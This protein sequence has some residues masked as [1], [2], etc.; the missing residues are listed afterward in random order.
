MK[1]SEKRE[2]PHRS[3]A[4]LPREGPEWGSQPPA[5]PLGPHLRPLACSGPLGPYRQIRVQI[6]PHW[7]TAE[8]QQDGLDKGPFSGLAHSG[9]PGSATCLLMGGIFAGRACWN[10]NPGSL[11]KANFAGLPLL[12]LMA[13]SQGGEG[14]EQK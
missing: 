7:A 4:G 12:W 14:L 6:Y 10:P 3:S 13:D 2:T 8:I 5:L 9:F 11:R 1:F